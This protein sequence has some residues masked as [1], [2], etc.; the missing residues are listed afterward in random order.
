MDGK[1]IAARTRLIP[2]KREISFDLI[3]GE[4]I[5]IHLKTGFYFNLEKTGTWVWSLIADGAEVGQI[6]ELL[7]DNYPDEPN[8]GTALDAF[9][10]HLLS[11]ALVIDAS[12]STNGDAPSTQP[13]RSSTDL[14]P[15]FLAPILNV[16]TDMRTLLLLDPIH[17][18][19]EAGWPASQPVDV[20]A[21]A[22]KTEEF[23]KQNG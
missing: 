6:L 2:N 11:E 7:Q 22:H 5:L 1:L 4:V 16:Y 3:D 21:A 17:E 9:L 14:S 12:N 18:V 20:D 13:S 15:T 23:S 10:E 8:V 19:D